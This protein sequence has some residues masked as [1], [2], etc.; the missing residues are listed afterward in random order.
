MADPHPKDCNLGSP[1][2]V[3]T[4]YIEMH[5]G[6][7]TA[8]GLALSFIAIAAVILV[9]GSQCYVMCVWARL[10]LVQ[11]ANVVPRMRVASTILYTRQGRSLYVLAGAA[12]TW[13]AHILSIGSIVVIRSSPRARRSS[14]SSRA[15]CKPVAF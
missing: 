14:K 2:W 11:R 13:H 4:V 8:Y 15:V 10:V 5:I 12:S 3:A 6:L 7:T 1:S 9:N